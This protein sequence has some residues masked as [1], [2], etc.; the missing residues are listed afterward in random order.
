MQKV[1]ALILVFKI[2]F[3]TKIMGQ[4]KP[5]LVFKN[6]QW[7]TLY[8][9]KAYQMPL[10]EVGAIIREK[11]PQMYSGFKSAKTENFFGSITEAVGLGL[12]VY[13]LGTSIY[14]KTS[15]NRTTLGLGAVIFIV[16][17]II[18]NDA[19]KEFKHI[20]DAINSNKTSSIKSKFELNLMDSNI[21]FAFKF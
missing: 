1:I 2:L 13:E 12:I 14:G 15:I 6:S 9:D 21:G 18:T 5:I 17:F 8:E 10:S 20:S 16:K 3:T 4:N 11:Y 7:L 19:A